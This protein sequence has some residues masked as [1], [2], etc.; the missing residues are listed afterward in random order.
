[1]IC[2]KL[3]AGSPD[4]GSFHAFNNDYVA[5][6]IG[7]RAY[8]AYFKKGSL[9]KDVRPVHDAAKWVPRGSGGRQACVG[10]DGYDWGWVY[11]AD[12]AWMAEPAG[13]HGSLAERR[14]DIEQAAKA[15]IERHTE[16]MAAK[17]RVPAD[18]M[19]CG[20]LPV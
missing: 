14:F 6:Q 2:N 20:V 4:P 11:P 16:K 15:F 19:T 10:P 8:T 9:A 18:C 5:K 3:N 1:L 17:D 12:G 7:G 13:R